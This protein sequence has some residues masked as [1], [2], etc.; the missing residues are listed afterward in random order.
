[1]EIGDLVRKG[2]VLATAVQGE[3]ASVAGPTVAL[4][5]GAGTELSAAGDTLV[6]TAAGYPRIE[7]KIVDGRQT[8][9]VCLVPLVCIGDDAMTATLTLAPPPPGGHLPTV[10][11]LAGLLGQEG[12]AYGLNREIL[13]DTLE[14]VRV[15]HRMI[16]GILVAMGLQPI[17][18]VDAHLR[19]ALEL[20][21]IPGKMLG[22]GRID[23]RERRMFPGVCKGQLIGVKV[24]A[25]RGAPGFNVLGEPI[26]QREGRELPLRFNENV[27]VDEASG[28]IRALRAG[29]LSVTQNTI[30]VTSKLTVAGDIDL[31][32]G[33]IDAKDAVEIGGTVQS[34]FQVKAQGDLLIGGGIRSATVS[35]RANIVVREGAGGRQTTIHAAGD[36]E[37]AYVEQSEMTAGGNIVV[38][39]NVYYSRLLAGGDILCR[40]ESRIFG[41]LLLAGGNL[42]VG[43]V[44]SDNAPPAQLVAGTDA[45]RYLRYEA[46][47]REIQGKEDELE[48]CLNLHGHN[49]GLPFHRFMTGELE[50]MHQELGRLD[51]ASDIHTA[52][53]QGPVGGVI[54]VQGMIHAG[55][56]LRI[57]NLTMVLETA[58]TACRLTR[59]GNRQEIVARPL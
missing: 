3:S 43:S 42:V 4:G 52:R 11:Q 39:K 50:E 49:S 19:L 51:L 57:G 44:G 30:R 59:S 5:V 35:S 32:T 17:H 16:G 34:G 53:H 37:I 36:I 7:R 55:T 40:H 54:V 25:T 29:V 20:G 15:E 21:S 2:Q 9:S 1:M 22:D 27:T 58:L 31:K 26:A 45:R 38:H 13:Q 10:D 41:G 8:P 23:F 14:R 24:A 33:N 48:H 46:L 47:L 12:I 6:A 56:R 18:G 28:E